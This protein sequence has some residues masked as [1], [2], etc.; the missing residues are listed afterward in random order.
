MASCMHGR[1][2]M[3]IKVK[4]SQAQI[5]AA[6]AEYIETK[7]GYAVVTNI[8]G[9]PVKGSR[10][11]YRK[12]MEM[13]GLGDVISCV[14]GVFIQF[15]VKKSV[16]EKLRPSQA[17]HKYRLELAGGLYYQVTCLDD[18]IEILSKRRFRA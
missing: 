2:R 6:I 11:I 1:I 13:S 12:N 18:A 10:K 15:E 4:Q 14:G 8:A 5:K 7:K 9:I 16:K 3:P 17:E